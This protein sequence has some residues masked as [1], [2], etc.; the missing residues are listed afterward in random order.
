MVGEVYANNITTYAVLVD[1]G[2]CC[3]GRRW[4]MRSGKA[5][6]RS[7]KL[8]W[9]FDSKLL[10][11]VAALGKRRRQPPATAAHPPTFLPEP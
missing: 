2:L 5:A 8:S 10:P 1:A 6:Q 11:F 9:Q 7:T 3:A 4:M